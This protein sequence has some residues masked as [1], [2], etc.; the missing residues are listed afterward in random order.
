[1]MAIGECNRGYI[2]EARAT[3]PGPARRTGGIHR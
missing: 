2:A 3:R 1:M